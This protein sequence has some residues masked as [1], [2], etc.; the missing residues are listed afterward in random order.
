MRVIRHHELV[1]PL[2]L[3][4]P[5]AAWERLYE[6]LRA[7]ARSNDIDLFIGRRLP[8]L[9]RRHGVLDVKA[10]PIVCAYPI[11]H[12]NRMLAVR[13]AENLA[14]R[15]VRDDLVR[16]DELTELIAELKQ[17]LED[18]DTLVISGTFVQTWGRIAG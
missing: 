11:G 9:M 4:P 6:I 1:W 10:R 8:R 13:F 17:H 12:S 18:P 5:L 3:D 2:T 16:P 7:Y 14:E 15:I